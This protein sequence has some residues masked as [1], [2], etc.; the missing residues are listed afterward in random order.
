MS[1]YPVDNIGMELAISYK[2]KIRKTATDGAD[3]F[4]PKV[5][6]TKADVLG[7][8]QSH[9]LSN[10]VI[11]DGLLNKAHLRAFDGSK[12]VRIATLPESASVETDG[13]L[14]T[15]TVKLQV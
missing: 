11:F 1:G 12:V 15:V 6:I 4:S 7:N 10:S 3:Y 13:F 14:A 8:V 5:R 9:P 2:T